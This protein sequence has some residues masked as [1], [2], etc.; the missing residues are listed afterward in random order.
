MAANPPLSEDELISV[1]RETVDRL[2]Q[3]CTLADLAT[4]RD[5]AN[6]CITCCILHNNSGLEKAWRDLA[7]EITKTMSSGLIIH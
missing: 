1:L 7:T 3:P 2:A 5:R 6:D 4:L